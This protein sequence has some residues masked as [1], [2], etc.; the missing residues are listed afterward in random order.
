[1]TVVM[2]DQPNFLVIHPLITSP[3]DNGPQG[4]GNISLT[5]NHPASIRRRNGHPELMVVRSIFFFYL[6]RLRVFH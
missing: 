5:A 6:D 4:C 1:M 3:F 2:N